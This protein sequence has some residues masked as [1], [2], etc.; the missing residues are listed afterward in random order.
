MEVMKNSDRFGGEDGWE[1]CESVFEGG[2]LFFFGG[3]PLVLIE[4]GQSQIEAECRFVLA[5]IAAVT[6]AEMEV[7]PLF[8][9]F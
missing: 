3:E 6:W 8:G 1:I 4:D 2:E 7:G 9:D 5:L